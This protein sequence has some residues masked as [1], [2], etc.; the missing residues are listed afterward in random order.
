MRAAAAYVSHHPGCSILPVARAVGPHR[1]VK[2][3]YEIVHRAIDAGLIRATV[4]SGRYTL[5]AT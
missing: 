3:G 4:T 5:E 2:Y 1:S